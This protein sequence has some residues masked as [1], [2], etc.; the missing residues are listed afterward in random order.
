MRVRAVIGSAE[1]D[2]RAASV[3]KVIHHRFAIFHKPL[4]KGYLNAVSL[5]YRILYLSGVKIESLA[6]EGGHLLN[7]CS[8]KVPEMKGGSEELLLIHFTAEGSPDH[9]GE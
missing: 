6:E 8:L 3:R 1:D 2:D 4:L 5:V 9:E 7:Q